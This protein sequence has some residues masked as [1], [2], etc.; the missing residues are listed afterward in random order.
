MIVL[1]MELHV[2]AGRRQDFISLINEIAKDSED[3]PGCLRFDVLQDEADPDRFFYYDVYAD[4]A[5]AEAHRETAHY[6]RYVEGTRG[7]FD[8]PSV[9]RWSTPVYPTADNWR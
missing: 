9:V 7:M 3:E 4:K 1:I 5:S 6:R 2:M 8:Q